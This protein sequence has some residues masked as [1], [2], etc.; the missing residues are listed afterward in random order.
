MANYSMQLR[1]VCDYY[2][3]EEVEKW[4]KSYKLEDYL[5]P[6]QLK[7]VN[8]TPIWNK[9]RLARKIVDNY[10]MSEIG[11]ETPALFKL[12]VINMMNQI[13]EEKL[14]II[15]TIAIEYDP[16]VNVDFTET[17]NRSANSN[18]QNNGSSNSNSNSNSSG[19]IANNDTPQNKI[20]KSDILNG[21]YATN[22]SGNETESNIKDTTTTINK[23][24][25]EN[26]EEYTRHLKGN[27]R[28]ICYLS[29]YD[30]TI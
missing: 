4:F 28:N 7:L 27:Q 26:Q 21:E 5:L 3:R 17:F 19:F 9:D 24:N 12:N 23:L 22:I 8:N 11:F 20:T 15:Y 14:P 2:T 13:M 16:L 18:S 6:E 1:K 25:N 10:F 30:K 29:S